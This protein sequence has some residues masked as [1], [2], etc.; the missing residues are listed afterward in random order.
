MEQSSLNPLRDGRD[1][2]LYVGTLNGIADT[3]RIGWQDF[4]AR[5]QR[6]VSTVIVAAGTDDAF[7]RAQGAS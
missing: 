1:R 4:K 3:C 5:L 7:R 6:L 2:F